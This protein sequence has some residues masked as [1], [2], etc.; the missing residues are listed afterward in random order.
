MFGKAPAQGHQD[1]VDEHQQD[2]Q[3]HAD[4]LA[5]FAVEEAKRDTYQSQDQ[6]CHGQG[7]AVVQLDQRNLP[8]ARVAG[9]LDQR[10]ERHERRSEPLRARGAALIERN[11]DV[12]F[13][14][15]GDRIL[16]RMIRVGLVRRSALEVKG[17]SLRGGLG[18]RIVRQRAACGQRHLGRVAL[19]IVGDEDP[20]PARA[21]SNYVLKIQKLVRELLDKNLRTDFVGYLAG[22]EAGL[23][24]D[25][26]AR[27]VGR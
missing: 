6:R 17:Q 2:G 26:V 7:Q 20:P 18:A 8:L 15:R 27:G 12:S 10:P 4:G 24:V 25:Q 16:F 19:C 22:L 23:H 1:V 5:A 3:D 9:K 11:R 21:R 14:E 13:A